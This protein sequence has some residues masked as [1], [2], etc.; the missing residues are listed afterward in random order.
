MSEHANRAMTQRTAPHE[1][2]MRKENLMKITIQ[3]TAA[4]AIAIAAIGML[5]ALRPSMR[6]RTRG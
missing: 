6:R 3:N 2:R 1:S 5:L 4:S